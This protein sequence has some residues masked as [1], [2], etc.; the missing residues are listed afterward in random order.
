MAGTG[1]EEIKKN[2][3]W[4]LDNTV[5]NYNVLSKLEPLIVF[6]TVSVGE[7]VMSMY[8]LRI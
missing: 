4:L 2:I 5:I 7:T 3:I 8:K 1:S 6:Q